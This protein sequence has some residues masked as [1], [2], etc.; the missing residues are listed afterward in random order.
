MGLVAEFHGSDPNVCRNRKSLIKKI[1]FGVLKKRLFYRKSLKIQYYQSIT[2]YL[3]LF[4]A[5]Q[6]AKKK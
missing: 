4:T 1:L 5:A 6:A 3:Q 2:A